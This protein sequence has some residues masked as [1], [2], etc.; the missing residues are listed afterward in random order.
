MNHNENRSQNEGRPQD[1]G[2]G[3]QYNYSAKEQAEL[4]KIREK[5]ITNQT[6]PELSGIEK[7]RKLDAGVTK[8]GMI[9]SLIFGIVG[10][11]LMGF[12]MSL[13]MTDLKEILGSYRDTALIIGIII[14]FVGMI[15]V[16]VAYPLYQHITARERKKI[17]PEI[18]RLTDELMNEGK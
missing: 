17:A 18:L 9:V 10:T 12:G 7:I 1:E 2:H 3:F 16:I 5:Y 11:L 13:I 6:S 15:G 4:K 14:G 8:K